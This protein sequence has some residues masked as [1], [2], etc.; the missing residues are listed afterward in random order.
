MQVKECVLIEPYTCKEDETIAE[1]A[2]KLRKT[3]LRHIFVVNAASHPVGVISVI[4]IN[5]RVVA[6][7]KDPKTLKAK[8]IMTK[9]VEIFKIEDD[10]KTV[11]EEMMKNNRA[12]N[13]VVKDDK[14]VGIITLSE[15]LRGLEK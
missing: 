12:M 10:V 14:M 6:E 9:P 4:D 11:A 1:V 5:N 8:D 2:R 7:E 3:T 13:P 15:A